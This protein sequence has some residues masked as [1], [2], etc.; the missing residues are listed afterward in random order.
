MTFVLSHVLNKYSSCSDRIFNRDVREPQPLLSLPTFPMDNPRVNCSCVNVCV[1]MGG[2]SLLRRSFVP[3]AMTDDNEVEI[4]ARQRGCGIC[5]PF[6]PQL[7]SD[8]RRVSVSETI[9]CRYPCRHDYKY[10]FQQ[11]IF[12]Y[13]TRIA[14]LKLMQGQLYL[15]RQIDMADTDNILSYF[16]LCIIY[17]YLIFFIVLFL[18][19]MF[20][21]HHVN[22]FYY[23]FLT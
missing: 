19:C 20:I 11:Q 4:V 6:V 10:Q 12:I 13:F 3:G 15:I 8:H 23:I 2:C 18:R 16:Y 14:L 21:P 1:W 5:L 7:F 9:K 22:L 17:V